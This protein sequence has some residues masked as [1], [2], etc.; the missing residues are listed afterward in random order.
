LALILFGAKKLPELAKGLGHGIKEFR[1]AS[2]EI[3]DELN[4]AIHEEPSTPPRR[5]ASP[6]SLPSQPE[7]TQPQQEESTSKMAAADDS[8][9]GGS[10]PTS[11][12]GESESKPPTREA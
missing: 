4:S 10:T 11:D 3:S 5:D 8:S 9:G 12:G 2:R 7:G 6:S 1:K